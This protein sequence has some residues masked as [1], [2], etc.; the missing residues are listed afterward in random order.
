[1]QTRHQRVAI[2]LSY[3]A[4][5]ATFS[6]LQDTAV[7]AQTASGPAVFSGL[8]GS[9]ELDVETPNNP[10]NDYEMVLHVDDPIWYEDE[11]A[12]S[13]DRGWGFEP[14]YEDDLPFGDRNG[15]GI[16]GPFD[17][18][19]NDRNNFGLDDEHYNSF[20]G[21]KSHPVAC[22]E[23][24]FDPEDRNGV[25]TMRSNRR[26]VSSALTFPTERTHSWR[27]LA[28]LNITTPIERSSKMVEKD[29]PR[30]SETT[31]LF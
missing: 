9:R 11:L 19:P 2:V 24:L 6:F 27:C 30:T 22:D 25:C 1:M 17:D 26:G 16:F 23:F 3:V 12:Y 7:Y 20:I 5:A 21:F 15:S 4:L 31:M 13:E 8:F 29:L 18:S 10:G 28:T 14:V